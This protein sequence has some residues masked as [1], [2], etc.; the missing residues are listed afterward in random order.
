MTIYVYEKCG[1][2][3][4]AL[5]RPFVTGDGIHLTGFNPDAWDQA[6]TK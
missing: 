4:N 2:C 3:R 6:F 5:N 1:T